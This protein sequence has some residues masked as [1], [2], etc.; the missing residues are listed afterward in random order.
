MSKIKSLAVYCGSS[1][2]APEVYQNAARDLGRLL[3]NHEIELVYGGSKKGL[4]GIL[5]KETLLNGGKVYGVI[6][7][8]LNDREG[9]YEEITEL[10]YVDTMHD[11]KQKMFEK[12]DAF[13][14]LP[15][16]LGTLD[17][18]C[19]I[20]TWKQIGLHNKLV[21]ILDINRYWSPLFIDYFEY[22]VKNNFVRSEDK[23]L[24]TVVAR[25]EDLVPFFSAEASNQQNYVAKWG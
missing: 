15:G 14:I 2:T 21:M 8:F 22:M 19:E 25:V 24:F 11:R 12:A 13:A 1:D 20:L 16:G 23:N 4:M 9:G 10:H 18:I 5:A 17:E 3:A 6:S 7:R